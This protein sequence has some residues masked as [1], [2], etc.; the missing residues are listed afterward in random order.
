[1]WFFVCGSDFEI[2]VFEFRV[3]L[4]NS[5]GEFNVVWMLKVRKFIDNVLLCKS[6]IL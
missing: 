2:C 3:F 6:S 1:M 5:F 4:I